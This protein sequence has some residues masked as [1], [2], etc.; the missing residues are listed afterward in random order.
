MHNTNKQKMN[1]DSEIVEAVKITIIKLISENVYTF[2]NT[3]LLL[4]N[5]I[6]QVY[7]WA[8]P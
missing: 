5:S 2:L 1:S 8:K 6:Q 4:V 3:Y 7:G